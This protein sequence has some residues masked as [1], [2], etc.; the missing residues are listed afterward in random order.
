MNGLSGQIKFDTQGFR[1][2]FLLE[3]IELTQSGINK[4]GVWN[5]TE[6]LNISRPIIEE[7][8]KIIEGSLKDKSFKVLVAL[9]RK[10][11]PHRLIKNLII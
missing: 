2:N 6:I 11:I 1:T 9:V 5:S 7:T 3:V 4:V 10:T 8:P